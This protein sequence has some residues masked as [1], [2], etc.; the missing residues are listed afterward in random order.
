MEK[1]TRVKQQLLR[2]VMVDQKG[3]LCLFWD[4]LVAQHAS[5]TRTCYGVSAGRAGHKWIT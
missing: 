4:G 1:L 3:E 5:S 2:M